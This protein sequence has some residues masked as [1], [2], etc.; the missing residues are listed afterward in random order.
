MSQAVTRKKAKK[1]L[2]SFF[3]ARI[4]H[5]GVFFMTTYHLRVKD[6][7]INQMRTEAKRRKRSACL[8]KRITIRRFS[9]KRSNYQSRCNWVEK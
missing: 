4:K 7:T 6:D 3:G 2:E 5:E 8:S 1:I 9:F